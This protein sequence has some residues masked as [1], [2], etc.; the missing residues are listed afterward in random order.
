MSLTFLQL[1]V[2]CS[3]WC[4]NITAPGPGLK[5]LSHRVGVL[6]HP[7]ALPGP[8]LSGG[9][10]AVTWDSTWKSRCQQSVGWIRMGLGP[11]LLEPC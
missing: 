1:K 4:G 3:S 9:E 2:S 6:A 7:C 5:L 11:L 8:D 10:Q